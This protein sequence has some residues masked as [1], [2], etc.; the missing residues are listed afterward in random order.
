MTFFEKI[1]K[2]RKIILLVL[3]L[4]S[5]F[6]RASLTYNNYINHGTEGWMDALYYISYGQDI[7][8]G[9]LYPSFGSSPYML[10]GPVIPFMVA[11]SQLATGDSILSVLMLNCLFGAFLVFVLFELGK[12]LINRTAGYIIALWSVFNISM[13]RFNYQILKEPLLFLLIPLIILCFANIYQKR[14]ILLNIIASSFLFSVLIHTDE[15]F[16]VYAPIF[17]VFVYLSSEAKRKLSSSIIWMTV[18][19]VTMIPWTIRNYRQFDEIVI[20]TPRTTVF[21][22]KLWGTD[23]TSMHF[24]G[25]DSYELEKSSFAESISRAEERFG[26]SPRKFGIYEKYFRAFV[27]YWQPTYFRLTYIQHGFRPVKWSLF[28]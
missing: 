16:F 21:T 17:L 8:D 27:N 13:I 28:Y 19:I 18:L 1:D 20:L 23:Y 3:F 4:F 15:R 7:A 26:R 22:S 11:I 25:E 24:V 9:D 5:F 12:I 14:N 2:H 10:S 6:L